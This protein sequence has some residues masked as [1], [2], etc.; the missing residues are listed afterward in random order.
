MMVRMSIVCAVLALAASPAMAWGYGHHS[1]HLGQSN[2]HVTTNVHIHGGYALGHGCHNTC[3]AAAHGQ[4]DT[5]SG[6]G[7]VYAHGG[8]AYAACGTSSYGH[9]HHG[10]CGC[11][12]TGTHVS[13]NNNININVSRHRHGYGHGYGRHAGLWGHGLRLPH[14]PVGHWAW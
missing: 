10:G 5:Q 12:G 9:G 2:V 14:L 4:G 8:D 13:V 3:Y 6:T 11:C 7:H 1:P